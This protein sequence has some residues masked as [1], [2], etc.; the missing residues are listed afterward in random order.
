MNFR[1]LTIGA[2][3]FTGMV[4]EC[5]MHAI[6][7]RKVCGDVGTGNQNRPVLHVLG[8][9]ELDVINHVQFFKKHRAYQTIEIATGDQPKLSSLIVA[10]SQNYLPS[11]GH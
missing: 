9:H 2:G 6:H 1:G 4:V 5:Q 7:V 8:V 10:P 3:D 11:P